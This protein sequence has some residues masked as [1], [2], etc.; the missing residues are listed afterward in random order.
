MKKRQPSC[1]FL[2][3]MLWVCGFFAL[4]SCIFVLT[5]VKADHLSKSAENLNHAILTAQNAVESIFSEYG[6]NGDDGGQTGIGLIDD[7]KN[8]DGQID[9]SQAGTGRAETYFDR[10]WT[11]VTAAE[12][13]FTLSVSTKE[14]EGLLLATAVVTDSDGETICQLDGSRS[15]NILKGGSY[16]KQN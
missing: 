11:P 5:F 10:N 13:I 2:M 6:E 9:S 12:A 14:E 7:A 1:A 15:L 3:E 4:A 16:E 8:G